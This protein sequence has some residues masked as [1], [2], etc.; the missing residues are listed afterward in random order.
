LSNLFFSNADYYKNEKFQK[1]MR[2]WNRYLTSDESDEEL[3]TMWEELLITDFYKSAKE[4]LKHNYDE[5][6]WK[7][8]LE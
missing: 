8:T 4:W 6:E 7:E 1:L 2:S 3:L 5:D